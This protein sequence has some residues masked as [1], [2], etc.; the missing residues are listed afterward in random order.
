MT[1]MS[2]RAERDGQ[3]F[4]SLPAEDLRRK[5]RAVLAHAVDG[6]RKNLKVYESLRNLNE[7]VGTEYGD[8]VLYELIQNAHDAQR[9]GDPGRIEVS[10]TIRSR[11]EGTLYVANSGGGFRWKDVDAVMNLATTA[12]EVGESIGNKGLGFRSVEAL[13]DDVRIYSR[14]GRE[15]SKY[16]DGYCFRF[17][18]R[19]EIEELLRADDVNMATASSVAR[20]VPRYL[21]PLPLTEQPDEVVSY[22]LRGY[23][24]VIV[25]P[26]CTADSIELARQQ[27]QAL[28]DLEVPLLLFLNRVTDFRINVRPPDGSVQRRRLSR[29]QNCLGSVPGIVGCSLHEV[30]V[31]EDRRFLVVRRKVDKA[32]VLDAVKRSVPRAPQIK[33][34]LEWKGQ[35]VVSVAVGLSSGA[36]ATG[37]LYNFLP[38]GDSAAAPL[39]GHLDAPFFADIDRRGADFELPLNATLMKAAAETCAYA[40]LYLAGLAVTNIPQRSVFDLVAWTGK[41]AGK[42]DAALDGMGSSLAAAPIVPVLAVDSIRWASLMETKLWPAGAFSL[43]KA[44]E[45]AKRT[46]ARLVS[47]EI[48]GE[49]LYRLETMA[50]R[51]YIGLPPSDRRLAEL[52]ERFARS[53]SDRQAAPRTWS[54]FYEDLCRVFKAADEELDALAGKAII[55]DRSRRL[56]PAGRHGSTS[57]GVPFVRDESTRRRRATG[58]A[59]L[60]PAKLTRRYCFVDEKI[61]FKPDTLT[62]FIDAG[63]VCLYDPVEALAGLR[64]ALGKRANDNRRREALK[65]AFSVSR[66][67]GIGIQDALRNARLQVPTSSGWKPATQ[68]AFSSSWTPV[69][70]TLENFLV[71]TANTSP[72]CRRMR[73][74]LLVNFAEWPP[75]P[76]ATKRQWVE[77]L[78]LLGVVDG[79]QPVAAVVQED[80]EGWNWNRLVRNGD[81]NQGLDGDWCREAS[82]STFRHPYTIYERRGEAWRLPGQIEHAKLSEI[83]KELFHELA[84]KHLEAYGNQYCAFDVA[85]FE[86]LTRHWDQ[87]TLPTPLATFLRSRAWIVVT[88]DDELLFRRAKE[89]WT[90]RIKRDQPPRFMERVSDTLSE[91]VQGSEEFAELVFGR[92]VGLR[93]WHSRDTAVERLQEL[94]VAARSLGTHERTDFRKEY[95]RAWLDV[96]STDTQLPRELVVAVIRDGGLEALAGDPEEAPTVIVT[97]NAQE[98]AA[99]LLSSAGHALLDVGEASTETVAKRLA[100]THSF[101][102]LGIDG[103]GVRLLVDGEPFVPRSSDPQ[104]SSL[105]LEWLPEVVLLGHE[106]LAEGLE[107]GVQRTTVER[108]IRAIRVRRCRSVSL[109]V[110]ENEVSPQGGINWYGFEHVEL[111]TLIL[112]ENVPLSWLTLSRDLSRTVQRLLHTRF[113]FLEPLLLRL[114]QSQDGSSLHPPSDEVLAAALRCDVA[115]LQD[116]RATLR[117]DLGHVLHLLMPIV[118]YFGDIELARRLE[119][120][121][122]RGQEQFDVFAWLGFRFPLSQPEPADLV[123]VCEGVSNRAALRRELGL[124]YERFNCVLV[125][126]GEAPLSNEDELRSM[127]DAYL[128]QMGSRILERLRRRHAT[129]FREG[130][131]LTVYVARKSLAFLEF[132]PK[133]ILTRETLDNEVVEA[134]VSRLLDETLGQDKEIDLPS[135][136]GL[137]EKNRKSIRE[138]ASHAIPIV[139]AWCHRNRIRVP[140]PWRSEDAQAVTRQLENS[141]LLDFEPVEDRRIPALCHRAGCWPDGMAQTLDTGALGLDAATVEAETKRRQKERERKIIEERSIDFAGTRLDPGDPSSF[142]ETFQ[143]LAAQNIADDEGWF[144]RSRRPRLAEFDGMDGGGR[145]SSS[146]AGGG[147]GRRRKQ[148]PEAQRQAMGLA[149]EW[150]AFQYLRRRYG[151]AVDET[152]W[153]SRNRAHFFAGDE[154]DDSAGYDFCV[155]TPQRE[156]LYEVKSSLEDAG[157]FELTPNE[158]RVAAS[159]P[160]RGRRQ[161]RILYVPFVFSPDHW[162]VLDLPNPMGEGSRNQFKQIGRGSVRFQFET[163]ALQRSS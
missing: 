86:R 138:F 48:E 155:K 3:A 113:R 22:A 50:G 106:F 33:R 110:D 20:T 151:E 76:G 42:L 143:Q 23:A 132:D 92:V 67:A 149:S 139:V 1:S 108:R 95:R 137:V 111:P 21:I 63:L 69:G 145:P 36:L 66:S 55:L 29:R 12:K 124:D 79:L 91:L 35:P 34:W 81:S 162:M 43:M 125:A 93:D 4:E 11:S 61:R 129:D 141:G 133:W 74:S 85:R 131:D 26:L 45:V 83:G 128:R 160:T 78:K 87:K 70:R 153:V 121:A 38:M 41:H 25:L 100:A 30:R 60:P 72:D 94:A 80:G 134:H 99:R 9:P 122:E 10:L 54:R 49:R 157:E 27:I 105:Q 120:D 135:S 24:S 158:M 101:R 68:T 89:C 112:S 44:S 98:S 154:G 127:Y 84:L 82:S 97:Q 8:R 37:R 103:N 52:S 17:A 96:S 142:A 2:G 115:S 146:K 14:K 107:R 150:L 118:A 73:D 51:K 90:A 19:E 119:R 117:T 88:I 159:V 13:T 109:V 56:R 5:V 59:P 116:H 144:E 152:C 65:W 123:A 40:A 147:N 62:A 161:Y 75:V 77:F 136:R 163:S 71:E 130:R 102:P 31:G 57:G 156:W 104:L 15:K 53:L 140:D 58:G 28:A 39:L 16:F 47:P 6:H 126:L 148:V 7:V 114:F 18:Q 32:R 46:D 64:S